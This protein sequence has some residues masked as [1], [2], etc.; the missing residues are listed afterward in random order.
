MPIV[1]DSAER[2]RS[3]RKD[4]SV[5]SKNCSN[6]RAAAL[7]SSLMKWIPPTSHRMNNRSCSHCLHSAA[8][9]VKKSVDLKVE[10]QPV[11]FRAVNAPLKFTV[12][13]G[14]PPAKKLEHN[15]VSA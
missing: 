14:H 11:A 5:P 13:P 6:V 2:H 10:Y 4:G 9:S 15:A 1:L 12:H 3:W 7:Q 8:A